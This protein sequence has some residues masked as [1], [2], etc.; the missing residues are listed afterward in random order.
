MMYWPEKK[1]DV[2]K[3]AFQTG[4][5]LGPARLTVKLSHARQRGETRLS[6]QSFT[7]LSEAAGIPIS[8]CE[9]LRRMLSRLRK[10]RMTEPEKKPT[11]S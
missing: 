1:S 5:K 11:K 8:R 7:S 10:T 6:R 3:G 9:C 4:V 2:T